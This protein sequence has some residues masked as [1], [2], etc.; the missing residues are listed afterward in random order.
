MLHLYVMAQFITQPASKRASLAWFKAGWLDSF[1][2]GW[3]DTNAVVSGQLISQSADGF[4]WSKAAE[5]G[6]K[7]FQGPSCSFLEALKQS[8]ITAQT[9]TG[10]KVSVQQT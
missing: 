10:L 3:V 8:V 5:N 2:T 1:K 7:A 9:Q 6:F 4:R